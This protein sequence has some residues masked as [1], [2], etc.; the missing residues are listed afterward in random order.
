MN[1]VNLKGRK[2][3]QIKDGEIYIGRAMYMGG[4]KLP[5]SKWANPYT[6]REFS[7]EEVLEKYKKYILNTP[8]LYNSLTELEGFT[9]A[10]WCHPEPCHGDILIELLETLNHSSAL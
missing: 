6:L 2:P 1:V 8:E 4:W 3:Q 7:R 10:C 9:L 5:K